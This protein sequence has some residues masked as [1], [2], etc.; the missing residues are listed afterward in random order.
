MT[1]SS[2]AIGSYNPAYDRTLE[3]GYVLPEDRPTL[4]LPPG[5]GPTGELIR[6]TTDIRY[7]PSVT[8][9]PGF[10]PGQEVGPGSPGIPAAL[11]IIGGAITL[12]IWLVRL[13]PAI[14]RY[15]ARM[16][17]SIGI[18]IAF[19]RKNVLMIAISAGW[20]A[21]GLWLSDI[22]NLDQDE[23]MRTALEIEAEGKKKKRKRYSIG[24]NPRV[25]TLAKVA[26]HTMR[27]LKRHQK[28][29]KQ[30]FP[31]TGRRGELAS[32]ERAHHRLIGKAVD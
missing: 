30:F 12:G 29:I 18:A 1:Q 21:A 9:S 13:A 2:R 19:I 28:V 4:L 20:V 11:P 8:P 26:R 3:P 6:L 27:L 31:Q 14:A 17:W 23:G 24:S 15:A 5:A 16:Q 25:G 7:T 10:L 22:L 32:R